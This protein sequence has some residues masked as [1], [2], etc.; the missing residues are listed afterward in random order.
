[1]ALILTVVGCGGGKRA[2]GERWRMMLAVRMGGE[3][4]G[5]SR[6][7]IYIYIY[8]YKPP[9]KSDGHAQSKGGDGCRA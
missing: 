5:K 3:D 9:G 1:M 2:R 8:I 7:H 4:K 6:G